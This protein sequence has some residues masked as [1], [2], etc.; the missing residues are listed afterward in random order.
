[1]SRKIR[2]DLIDNLSKATIGLS[3][4]D[5]TSDANKPISVA[6]QAA[7]DSKAASTVVTTTVS[8]LMSFSDKLKLNGIAAGATVNDTDT[9]L[10]NRSNHTGTQAIS[11]IVG[12]QSIL[13]GKAST[14]LVTTSSDG[15]LSSADKL[16]LNSVSTGATANSTDAEL[17]NRSTHTGTQSA[18]TL[19]E[20]ASVKLLTA[21]ERDKLA[22]IALNA[23]ANATDALLRDRTTH[24]GSQP[25]STITNLQS[26][27][28]G[29]ESLASKGVANGY[30]ALGADGKIPSINLPDSGSYKG[31]WDASTNTPTIV[32][33]VGSN[34]DN[35]TV[36][37]SGTQSITGAS[38]TFEIGDQLRFTTNGNKWERIPNYQAVSSVAGLTG[39]IASSAL[40]TALV[41]TKTDVGLSNVDNTSDINKPISTAVQ[42]ALNTKASTSV[43]TTTTSG[44]MSATDKTKLNGISTGATAN[45]TDSALRDRSTHT[46]T[47]SISTIANLQN[48]LDVKEPILNSGTTIQYYRG[49]KSWQTLD[50]T[51]VGL[52]NVDNT[53]DINKPISTAVQTALTS[54]NNLITAAQAAADAA[55]KG[56]SFKTIS[57]VAGLVADYVC[58]GTA[59]HVQFNE[60]IA[61]LGANGGT[62]LVRSSFNPYRFAETVVVPNNVTIIGELLTRN[63]SYGVLIKTAAGVNLE[64][65]FA[66][67][68]TVGN[69]VRN[70]RFENIAFDGNLT[71]NWCVKY[72]N[73]DY[74]KH[75]NCRFINS[76]NGIFAGYDGPAAPEVS[77]I[78][79]GVYLHS[80]NVS[81][82]GGVGV[83]FEYQTQ[84]WISD[85]WFTT[86]S[87][88]AAWISLKCSD[89][90][91]IVNSEFNTAT[92]CFVFE[93]VYTGGAYDYPCQYNTA[94]GCVF[95][96][97]N[98]MW[99]DTRTH[100]SSI[101][102]TIIGSTSGSVTTTSDLAG[103]GNT[104]ILSNY[105]RL[106]A[107][108]TVGGVSIFG[109]GDVGTI[110]LAYGGTG[111]TTAAAARTNLGLSNV[112]NTSDI[113]KPISTAVQ[114]ALNGKASTAAA[115]T[116]TNGLLSS[117]DKVKLD[118]LV[119][120]VQSIDS[121]LSSTFS[122]TKILKVKDYF[123]Y[124]TIDIDNRAFFFHGEGKTRSNDEFSVRIDRRSDF[125]GGTFGFLNSALKINS[126]ITGQSQSFEAGIVIVQDN[127]ANTTGSFATTP[128]HHGMV[129]QHNRFGTAPGFCL[130]L[131][132]VDKGAANP[133][134]G[135][136]A[137]E[138]DIQGQGGDSN[139]SR[140]GSA[141]I[142]R[143]MGGLAG[144][145]GEAC[146]AGYGIV[147][148]KQPDDSADNYFDVGVGFGRPYATTK[149]NIGLD[150]SNAICNYS[151]LR[152]ANNVIDWSSD[153][154]RAT[155]Y[156]SASQRLRYQAPSSKVFDFLDNGSFNLTGPITIFGTQVLTSRRTG[157]TAD[158]GTAKRTTNTTYSGT[159]EATYTQATIQA[160]MNVVKAQSETIKALK[161][162]LIAHGLIGS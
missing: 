94:V 20:S 119:T 152:L 103:T 52:P 47:Q 98:E 61:A 142:V 38:T 131:E 109:T 42:T 97:Q 153:G 48:T 27:L 100:P 67:T 113:N 71:T 127:M 135:C 46:G 118:G 6:V 111:A 69:L 132:A 54:A 25:I 9:N 92:R 51:A 13:D 126:T 74:I 87:T 8:G 17:R 65:I 115:T 31:N 39:P 154:S 161:D 45:A 18:D 11:T 24:T 10:K 125:N 102:F 88:T 1:M 121:S 116:T 70:V 104:V 62:I 59:D 60:A 137:M 14:S 85:C 129:I 83:R 107:I 26:T 35:Y 22:N 93:D 150:F 110:G 43:V 19:V 50:K 140:Y 130:V 157:W 21:S 32:A 138:I 75:Y 80:C 149:F 64:S 151:A 30:A 23:T 114:T 95:A 7:L 162:D 112:D 49:D 78:P 117:T 36:N 28:D 34:G 143:R 128:Q 3:E 63:A 120:T 91:K 159:A 141:Y 29:K 145:T 90:I 77:A 79:G 155:W 72:I 57:R 133:S 105:V 86:G 81:C 139:R 5:N 40:K 148:S 4:V 134:E 146:V 66:V 33:G 96:H 101:R 144:W 147:F 12:L 106:P 41:L 53:S 68:G 2:T 99:T 160:L 122:P 37:V 73:A 82:R 84:C 15:L 108:K 89:K 158:S 123:G 56:R 58:D 55:A 76:T 156:D 124:P 16:K 136:G 44:L